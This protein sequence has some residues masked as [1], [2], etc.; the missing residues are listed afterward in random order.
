M[1]DFT[2]PES[3]TSE[4]VSVSPIT[5]HVGTTGEHGDFASGSAIDSLTP[6]KVDVSPKTTLGGATKDTVE[7]GVLDWDLGKKSVIF[8]EEEPST[9]EGQVPGDVV[10]ERGDDAGGGLF[11]GDSTGG[12]SITVEGEGFAEGD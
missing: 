10:G 3:F 9:G 1:R 8:K 12:G 6:V 11:F 7:I 5:W 4:L 2:S